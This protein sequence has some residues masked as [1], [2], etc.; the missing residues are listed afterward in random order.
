MTSLLSLIEK[1]SLFPCPPY[2]SFI[3]LSMY[4][5]PALCRTVPYPFGSPC[6]TLRSLKSSGAGTAVKG[7]GDTCKYWWTGS[8]SALGKWAQGRFSAEV[9]WEQ[10]PGPCKGSQRGEEEQRELPH[11]DPERRDAEVSEV[12]ASSLAT[13]VPLELCLVSS[14]CDLP[15]ALMLTHQVHLFPQGAASQSL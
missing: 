14:P 2:L 11:K 6:G 9:T 13:G 5:A 7:D 1:P 15:F 12:Q 10:R 4:Q 8:H 3:Y